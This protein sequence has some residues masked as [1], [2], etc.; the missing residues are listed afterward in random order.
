ML[1]EEDRDGWGSRDCNFKLNTKD[2]GTWGRWHLCRPE[3]SPF[4]FNTL[5]KTESQGCLALPTTQ[6][7][8]EGLSLGWGEAAALPLPC[9]RPVRH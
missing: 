9:W 1:C 6:R 3:A 2:W 7:Q 5:Q 4:C 8:H